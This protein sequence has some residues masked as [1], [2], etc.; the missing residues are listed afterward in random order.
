MLAA[1]DSSILFSPPFAF[2]AAAVILPSQHRDLFWL[3]PLIRS[4]SRG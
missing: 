3:Y 2:D 4:S 1:L